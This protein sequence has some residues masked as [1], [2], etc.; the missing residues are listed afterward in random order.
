MQNLFFQ[1]YLKYKNKYTE[2][3]GGNKR[4]DEYTVCEIEKKLLKKPSNVLIY[5]M[6]FP[7]FLDSGPTDFYKLTDETLIKYIKDLQKIIPDFYIILTTGETSHIT[8]R[9]SSNMEN[10]LSE[11]YTHIFP[12]SHR[13]RAETIINEKKLLLRDVSILLIRNGT[14][15]YAISF[16]NLRSNTIDHT[17]L[18]KVNANQKMYPYIN[19][20]LKKNPEYMAKLL[21]FK[22]KN[23][24]GPGASMLGYFNYYKNLGVSE[25]NIKIIFNTDKDIDIMSAFSSL[26]EFSHV[27]FI[28]FCCDDKKIVS[29]QLSINT[30]D[31]YTVQNEPLNAEKII[32]LL[33]HIHPNPISNKSALLNFNMGNGFTNFII[34][35]LLTK[36]NSER[37]RPLIIS[38]TENVNRFNGMDTPTIAENIFNHIC[39]ISSMVSFW[40][41]N[42]GYT[43]V[44]ANIFNI[45]KD[46]L[47]TK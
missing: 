22:S 15:G 28:G 47:F 16:T 17:S 33:S 44:N 18:Q 25:D 29:E 6:Q 13:A 3:K 38:K 35:E 42:L 46:T 32:T 21:S 43:S 39:G 20:E 4:Q 27:I 45:S 23:L 40:N 9:D 37:F 14:L 30:H 31:G 1:K 12:D 34:P 10:I 36:L 24:E 8:E 7:L 5:T 2:L 41:S 11:K 19:R 26:N